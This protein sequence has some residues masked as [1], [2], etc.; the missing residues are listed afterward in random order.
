LIPRLLL[1]TPL[2]LEVELLTPGSCLPETPTCRGRLFPTYLFKPF[3]S[4]VPPVTSILSDPLQFWSSMQAER[5]QRNES[6]LDSGR[7]QRLALLL[8]NATQHTSGYFGSDVKVAYQ[9]A[10]RLLAH[11]SA[12]RGFGLSATQDVH[13]TEV[14]LEVGMVGASET[15]CSWRSWGREGGTPLLEGAPPLA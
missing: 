11:E 4:R 14:G 13:F 1:F 3:Y 2:S 6:G 12:Q 7:S 10:T 8:R 5:L 15:A 9:L